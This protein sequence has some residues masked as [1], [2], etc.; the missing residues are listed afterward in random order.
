MWL[1]LTLCL[2]LPVTLLRPKLGLVT[3]V[4]LL[5]FMPRYL[6]IGLGDE[7]FALSPRRIALLAFAGGMLTHMI[8]REDML[9]RAALVVNAHRLIV[10]LIVISVLVRALST[11]L[12]SGMTFQLVYVVDNVLITLIPAIGVLLLINS[13]GDERRIIMAMLVA[14]C[15]ASILAVLEAIKGGMILQGLVSVSV[16]EAG[17]SGLTDIF[18]GSA[19]RSKALFDNPLLLAEFACVVWPWGVYLYHAAQSQPQKILA[20]SSIV[21]APV[22]IYCTHA[23]SGWLVWALGV[24]AFA[25]I[26]GWDKSSRIARAP[27]VIVVLI[28]LS[29]IGLV[30]FQMVT[31]A[32]SAIGDGV[33]G[34]RS[35]VERLNQ[36]AVV[37]TAMT[38]SPA[39]GYGMTRNILTDL[40]SLDHIDNYWLRLILEGG[41]VL[42]AVFLLLAVKSLLMVVSG[43]VN[44]ISRNS[45]LFMS[46]ALVSI[47]SLLA[48]KSFV[49]MPTN[50]SIFFIIL[51]LAMRRDFWNQV[52]ISH[53]RASLSQ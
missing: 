49:S 47:M 21:A 8:F 48:Y 9:N 6:G 43:R 14:L 26:R 51:A 20:I 44:A 27:L 40:E 1:S 13:A 5:A 50:N 22:A 15:V 35:I 7:G 17:R 41:L 37:V 32:V 53:A 31:N 11:A 12:N 2:L 34:T 36:Y 19:Y 33:E 18:R 28:G 46:A 42:L 45:R 3:L 52:V 38:E 4:F 16:E 29:G 24:L 23:R 10:A 25:A 39:L 30:V